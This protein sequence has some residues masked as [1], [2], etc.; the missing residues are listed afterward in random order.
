MAEKDSEPG[1]SL[2]KTVKSKRLK[3]NSFESNDSLV[4]IDNLY[5]SFVFVTL[6]HSVTLEDGSSSQRA[7]AVVGGSQ[8]S[9]QT[10]SR[11]LGSKAA[12]ETGQQKSCL[13]SRRIR[14]QAIVNKDGIRLTNWWR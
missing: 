7:P 6:L 12:E 2:I 14:S 9:T 5:R 3:F 13:W 4:Y 1:H 10:S 11:A 8:S